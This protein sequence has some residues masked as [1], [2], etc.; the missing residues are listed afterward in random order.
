VYPGGSQQAGKAQ[1]TEHF[2]SSI[3][4]SLR[5]NST[6][7]RP[8]PDLP[9]KTRDFLQSRPR[10][11]SLC[12]FLA[13]PCARVGT[14][15]V[16]QGVTDPLPSLQATSSAVQQCQQDLASHTRSGDG[17]SVTD[18]DALLSAGRKEEVSLETRGLGFSHTLWHGS[19]AGMQL[20]PTTEGQG[21]PTSCLLPCATHAIWWEASAWLRA[22]QTRAQPAPMGQRCRLGKYRSGGTPQHRSCSMFQ[23]RVGHPCASPGPWGTSRPRRQH[24]LCREGEPLQITSMFDNHKKGLRPER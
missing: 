24:P 21:M 11:R 20:S 23:W 6:S 16:P 3:T 13:G 12:G 22:L 15:W 5:S 17:F 7:C 4:C 14:T 8:P 2:S 19:L 9:L 10:C 1:G 18:G